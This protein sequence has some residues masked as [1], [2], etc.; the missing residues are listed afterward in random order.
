MKYSQALQYIHSLSVF[1]S[2]PGLCR[3]TELADKLGNP[4]QNL[5]FIHIAGTNGKGSTCAMTAATLTDAGYKTGLFISPYV[6]E[7]CERIQINGNYIPKRTLARLCEKVKAVADTMDDHPTEFE[8]ITAVMFL[9]FKEQKVDYAVVEVG[10]GGRLDSTNIITPVVCAIT[11]IA[12]DHKEVLGDTVE[13]IAP[14]KAGII[15]KGVPIVLAPQE[16]ESA[17][18]TVNKIATKQ[19]APLYKVKPLKS[20]DIGL[21]GAHQ[22]QNAATAQKICE[23]LNIPQKSIDY[24]IK[25]AFLPARV[26]YICKYPDVIL[27]GSHNPDG[28]AALYQIIKDK[29]PVLILGMMRD[30]D[31]AAVIKMLAPVSSA[32]ITV[33]VRSNKRSETAE[34]LCRQAQKYTAAY[35]A[36]N[37]ISALK[38]AAELQNGTV[39]ICGS[40][41]LAGDIRKTAIKFFNST[42]D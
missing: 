34:N 18:Q 33:T 29:A 2:K 32:V 15:K 16:F 35:A 25:N 11:K 14:E 20:A 19:D 6:T 39:V 13:K 30:K 7:F 36:K 3:I 8:I 37:Y 31:S 23:L 38:K 10:L 40:L 42:T 21:I 1:G 5:K 26:E 24:G 22:L 27:D 9:Y 41:Y 4:Q 12:L 17:V 28:A